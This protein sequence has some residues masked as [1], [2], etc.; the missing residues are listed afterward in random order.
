MP[1]TALK[2]NNMVDL[3]TLSL[4]QLQLVAHNQRIYSGKVKDEVIKE[5]NKRENKE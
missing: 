2:Y 3:T 5:I 1:S 4:E